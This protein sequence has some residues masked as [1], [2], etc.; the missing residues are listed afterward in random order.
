M[1]NGIAKYTKED[2]QKYCKQ[3][4][5]DTCKLKNE[6]CINENGQLRLKGHTA[7]EDFQSSY[8]TMMTEITTS[9]YNTKED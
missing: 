2:G 3:H 1:I 8:N 9:L 7:Y 4:Q 5:C 6:V